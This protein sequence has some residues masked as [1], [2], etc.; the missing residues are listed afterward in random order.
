MHIQRLAVTL[1]YQVFVYGW[2]FHRSFEELS[3]LVEVV[4]CTQIRTTLFHYLHYLK[5]FSIFHTSCCLK[6]GYFGVTCL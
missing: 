4:H 2:N 5:V 3:S 1:A 6:W